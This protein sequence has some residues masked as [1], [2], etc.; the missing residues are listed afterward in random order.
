MKLD[1]L[2]SAPPPGSRP[3]AIIIDTTSVSQTIQSFVFSIE[4]GSGSWT[5]FDS[6]LRHLTPEGASLVVT[7]EV[8]REI[9]VW[10]GTIF[11]L[12]CWTSVKPNLS[13]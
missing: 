7:R 11:C 5:E 12:Y 13:D 6:F 2:I 10:G 9:E 4:N 1:E 8:L 3:R